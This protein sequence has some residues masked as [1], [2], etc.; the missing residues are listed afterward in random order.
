MN[1][2]RCRALITLFGV[3]ALLPLTGRAELPM[4]PEKV[5]PIA[6][7]ARYRTSR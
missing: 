5:E 3:V 6:K 2:L 1:T 7:G 4:A